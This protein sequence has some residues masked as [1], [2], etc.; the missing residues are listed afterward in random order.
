[1]RCLVLILALGVF[2][3]MPAGTSFANEAPLREKVKAVA[4]AEGEKVQ[5][6]AW[7]TLPEMHIAPDYRTMGSEDMAF[8]MQKIPGCYFFVGSS[9]AEKGMNYG[10]HHPKFDFYESALPIAVALMTGT[11]LD[12]L[13]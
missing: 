5:A 12:L 2:A 9:N 13:H 11:V 4:K 7:A 6:A 3:G 8:V 10:H 1:M